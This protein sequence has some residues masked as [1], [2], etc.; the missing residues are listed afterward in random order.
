MSQTAEELQRPAEM[1]QGEGGCYGKS[2]T[3][4]VN[5]GSQQ[6]FR[7]AL[8]TLV[9]RSMATMYLFHVHYFVCYS[10]QEYNTWQSSNTNRWDALFFFVFTEPW[11]L[12][13]YRELLLE[14]GGGHE[15]PQQSQWQSFCRAR[16]LPKV[17][18]FFVFCFVFLNHENLGMVLVPFSLSLHSS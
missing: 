14:G 1:V 2:H 16:I 10:V 9:Y 17:W 12:E 18:G 15:I 8:Y 4:K 5:E 6:S 3:G 7:E 13:I 11:K